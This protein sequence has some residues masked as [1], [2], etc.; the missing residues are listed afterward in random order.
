MLSYRKIIVNVVEK[1]CMARKNVFVVQLEKFGTRSEKGSP[2]LA[3]AVRD[4]LQIENTIQY[5]YY[6]GIN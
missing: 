3:Y 1:I 2:P 5:N 6:I 4:P